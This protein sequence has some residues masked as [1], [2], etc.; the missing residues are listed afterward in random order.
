MVD[1]GNE[2][3]AP[4]ELSERP[5]RLRLTGRVD[6][7]VLADRILAECGADPPIDA[8]E[9]AHL[10]GYSVRN[11]Q[12]RR[13]GDTIHVPL[14]REASAVQWYCAHELAHGL[15]EEHALPNTERNANALAGCLL[16]PR[17]VLL[18]RPGLQDAI[19]ACPS[20]T[21]LI[22][23][24]RL[25]EVHGGG[26]ALLS[27]TGRVIRRYGARVEWSQSFEFRARLGVRR[28]VR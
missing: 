18:K 7:E 12:P 4:V 16:A 20:A 22:V 6:V 21:P 24:R 14:K 28:V 15:L 13:E 23:A 10:C 26:A 3:N 11:G 25:V 9:L 5:P 2:S 1:A 8:L 27:G 19:A 17:S